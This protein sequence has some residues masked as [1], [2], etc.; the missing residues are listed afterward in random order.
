MKQRIFWTIPWC[1]TKAKKLVAQLLGNPLLST[2]SYSCEECEFH[3]HEKCAQA[4]LEINHHRLHWEHPFLILRKGVGCCDL[5]QEPGQIFIYRCPFCAFSLDVKCALFSLGQN[6]LESKY[7]AHLH[8]LLFIENHKDELKKFISFTCEEPLTD[9]IYICIDC[10]IYFH[11]KCA[12]LP[13]EINHPCHRLHPFFV[14]FSEQR[15]LFCN[16]SFAKLIIS[17]TFIVVLL[18]IL[19]LTLNVYGLALLLEIK[20]IMSTP[21]ACYGDRNHLFVM[22]AALRGINLSYMCSTC[23]L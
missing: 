3:L 22:N 15:R 1:T 6:L 11:K 17:D 12:Q 14:E 9:S 2:Q 18:A 4:P 8:P 10:R 13:T 20:L 21:L 19:T 23:H 5:C 16:A 7:N